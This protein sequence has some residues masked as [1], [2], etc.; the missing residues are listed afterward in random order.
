M[1][2]ISLASFFAYYDISNYAYISPS[3]KEQ[4][5]LLD[6]D[7]ALGASMTV[8]G[9]VIGSFGITAYADRYGRKPAIIISITTL[10]A[11]SMLAAV[12]QN[13]T[14]LIAFRLL[15]GIGIGSEIAVVGSYIA[16][17]S[18]RTKRGRYTSLILVLGW[19]GIT[20]SGPIALSLIQEGQ[21]GKMVIEP[22]RVILGL[23]AVPA[24]IGLVLRLKM[25]ES[26]RWLLSRGRLKETNQSLIALG[27]QRIGGSTDAHS[28]PNAIY[29]QEQQPQQGKQY[30]SDLSLK[31]TKQTAV[32]KNVASTSLLLTLRYYTKSRILI[33]ATVWFLVLIPIYSSLLL[34]TEYVRQ[35]YDVVDSVFINVIASTGF[36]AGGLWAITCADKFERKY[37][38]V[39]ASVI[40]ASAF[41]LRGALIQDY[42]G[43]VASSTL[44]F[45]ANAWLMTSLI[46]YTGENFP[47]LIR[48]TG[49]GIV[50]G[51]GRLIAT[52]GPFIF[53]LLQPFGFFNMMIGLALFPIAASI[54]MLIVGK[55]TLNVSL[56]TLNR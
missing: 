21:S 46:A 35:G 22:W 32:P 7:I 13:M 37:Q 16:E 42:F 51:V 17:M 39:I 44:A 56:E 31:D 19:T 43:L 12:S 18:P 10:A 45:G 1:L 4:W 24:L 33:L 38:I 9:Y 28:T 20:L 2:A 11:G 53:V 5:N 29:W 36:V 54:I 50:E 49:T 48:S 27:M 47:T 41:I 25:Q 23:A 34:V 8:L 6:S 40:M 15:T 30:Q 52:S 14:Q 26:L 55:N 3:I